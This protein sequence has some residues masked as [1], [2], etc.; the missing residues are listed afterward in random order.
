MLFPGG[1]HAY[2]DPLCTTVNLSH[3]GNLSPL[4]FKIFLVDANGVRPEVAWCIWKSHPLKHAVQIRSDFEDLVVADDI[5]VSLTRT[6]GVGNRFVLDL[7]DARYMKAAREGL[8]RETGLE[9][10]VTK[11]IWR[12]LVVLICNHR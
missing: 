12:K 9:D 5:L 3:D 2:Q 1:A 4:L 7:I 8:A 10:E 11:C 6:P